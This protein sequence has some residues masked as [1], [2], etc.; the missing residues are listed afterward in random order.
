MRV[1][2][3]LILIII[4]GGCGSKPLY[5]WGSYE[6]T[7]HRHYSDATNSSPN[8]EIETLSKDLIK[9][10]EVHLPLPPGYHA[11]LGYLYYQVGNTNMAKEE[12]QMEKIKYPKSA[13]LMERYLTK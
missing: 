11:Y 12:F 10:Q 9:S 5:Y 1:L 3:F 2:F 7:L 4:F 13:T 8:Q 6:S